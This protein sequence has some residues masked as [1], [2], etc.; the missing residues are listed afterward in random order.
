MSQYLGISAMSVDPLPQLYWPDPQAGGA[1]IV[2]S[3]R[4]PVRLSCVAC[5]NAVGLSV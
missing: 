5:W 2:H 1:P 3:R 4:T